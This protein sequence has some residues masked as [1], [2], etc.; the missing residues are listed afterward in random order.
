LGITLTLEWIKHFKL[1][2]Y[3]EEKKNSPRLT[4]INLCHFCVFSDNVLTTS[5]VVNSTTYHVDHPELLVFHIVT[6]GA[7]FGAM[8][9]WFDINRFKGAA[10]EVQ[11]VDD[12]TWLNALYV[13]V[14]KQLQ[15]AET[16]NYYFTGTHNALVS[17]LVV[18]AVRSSAMD[19]FIRNITTNCG[20][21]WSCTNWGCVLLSSA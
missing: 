17:L 4:D 9:A 5:V 20:E 10:I 7:N 18:E 3:M 6:D 12:L 16:H 21:H 11:N 15:D 19:K 14:L 8:Q 2:K 1:Q 13:P